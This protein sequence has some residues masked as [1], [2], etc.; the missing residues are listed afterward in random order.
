MEQLRD[1][2]KDSHIRLLFVQFVREKQTVKK[3]LDRVS[4]PREE[5]AQTL[6]PVYLVGVRKR[7]DFIVLTNLEQHLQ[8]L[9]RNA[10]EISLPRCANFVVGQC[11]IVGYFAHLIVE[12]AQRDVAIFQQSKHTALTKCADVRTNVHSQT[13]KCGDSIRFFQI[14]QHCAEVKYEFHTLVQLPVFTSL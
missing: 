13:V 3:V 2:L 7:I 9:C 4:V 8:T 12:I 1:A 11:W 10:F 6:R 5:I 14:H